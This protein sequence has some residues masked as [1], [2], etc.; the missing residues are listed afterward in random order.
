MTTRSALQILGLSLL[1]WAVTIGL[2]W[3][4]VEAVR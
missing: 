3:L 4:F 2:V 1:S